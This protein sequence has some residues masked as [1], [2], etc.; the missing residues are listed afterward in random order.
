MMPRGVSEKTARTKS[1]I[2]SSGIVPVSKVSTI[3]DT[4]SATPM[5]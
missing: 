1:V 4:G 5:A 3:T 2:C